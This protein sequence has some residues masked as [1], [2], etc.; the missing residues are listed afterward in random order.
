MAVKSRDSQFFCHH[1]I[2]DSGYLA[3][4]FFAHEAVRHGQ[5]PG[6]AQKDLNIQLGVGADDGVG[7]F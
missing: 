3:E 1:L 5:S 2:V 4:R 6:D 7:V